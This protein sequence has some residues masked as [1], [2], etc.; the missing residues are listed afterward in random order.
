MFGPGSKSA[1]RP[2]LVLISYLDPGI[3][4]QKYVWT[5]ILPHFYKA[6]VDLQIVKVNI[7]GIWNQELKCINM[8]GPG[9]YLINIRHLS[10]YKL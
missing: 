10:T 4:M 5:R 2:Y 7:N 6:V 3:I 8:F 1:A 9:S